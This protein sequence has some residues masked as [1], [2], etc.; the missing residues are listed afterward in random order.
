MLDA[1]LTRPSALALNLLLLVGLV[2]AVI[3][4]ILRKLLSVG[5]SSYKSCGEAA[6]EDSRWIQDWDAPWM[7]LLPRYLRDKTL[8]VAYLRNGAKV[9]EHQYRRVQLRF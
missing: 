2:T 4:F 5:I 9:M 8:A 6:D 7:E 3:V 1:S